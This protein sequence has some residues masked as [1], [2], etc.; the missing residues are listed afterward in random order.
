MARADEKP[1]DYKGPREPIQLKNPCGW[2]NSG[3]HAHCVHEIPYYAK[4]WLCG[5]ECNKSW[6]PQQLMAGTIFKTT[7]RK[8]KENTD[9]VQSVQLLEQSGQP[10]STSSSP[11]TL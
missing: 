10:E 7:K 11:G 4:L 9:E 1:Q 5:C 6:K 8:D 2:C 3:D